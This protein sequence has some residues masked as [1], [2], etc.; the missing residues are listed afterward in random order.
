MGAF[1][2]RRLAHSGLAERRQEYDPA[3]G[4]DPVGDALGVAV[5]IEAQLADLAAQMAAVGLA[6]RCGVLGEPVDLLLRD[7]VLAGG[8]ALEPKAHLRLDLDRVPLTVHNFDDIWHGC[9]GP[10]GP[11]SG[12]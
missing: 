9:Y 10:M 12:Q 2:L 5:E 8:E 6:E 7:D 1:H 11:A 3:A 4:G